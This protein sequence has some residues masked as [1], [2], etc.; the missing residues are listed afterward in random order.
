MAALSTTQ[1]TLLIA[2]GVIVVAGIV[3]FLFLRKRRT[4]K[5][6]ARF[7]G[8]EYTRAVQEG[9]N[10]RHAEAGFEKRTERVDAFHVRP[11]TSGDR[12][13]FVESWRRVQARFV[14]GPAGAL[15]EADQLLGD[16]IS[17]RGYPVSDFEQPAAD[18]SVDHPLVLKTYRTAHEVALRQTRGQANAEDLRQA[19]VH[20]RTLFEELVNEQEMPPYEGCIMIS[21]RAGYTLAIVELVLMAAV[22]GIPPAQ[23]QTHISLHNFMGSDGKNPYTDLVRDSAGNL[24]GTTGL[25]GAS[26]QGVVFKLDPT[27]TETVLYS[28]AEGPDGALPWAG[29][30]R[31]STGNLYGTTVT[32]GTS[33]YGVVF[34]VDTTDTETVLYS[35]TGGTDGA[36]PYAGVIRDSAG[37]LYGTTLY[38]G[39]TGCGTASARLGPIQQACCFP[40]AE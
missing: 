34:K 37:N 7:G 19:M 21:G 26:G 10:R 35:F 8:A 39:L 11:L 1:L 12:A 32:G 36:N 17:A 13:R 16:V 5:L 3:A 18:I 9:G 14:D 30:I 24:Y 31:D 27:G 33:G 40:A 15:T 25:G 20:Y 2:L 22:G 6:R 23:A 38:G 29:L 4:E 28:F